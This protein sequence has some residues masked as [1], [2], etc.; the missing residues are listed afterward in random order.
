ME[1]IE[2]ELDTEVK[3]DGGMTVGLKL[4]GLGLMDYRIDGKR[5]LSESEAEY[6]QRQVQ[7]PD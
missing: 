2:L 6:N 1:L 4:Y 3:A 5:K 7:P